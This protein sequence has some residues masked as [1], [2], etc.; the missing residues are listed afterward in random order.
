MV[1]KFP[2]ADLSTMTSAGYQSDKVTKP[3]VLRNFTSRWCFY[4]RRHWGRIKCII[5]FSNDN[6]VA[7]CELCCFRLTRAY[8]RARRLQTVYITGVSVVTVCHDYVTIVLECSGLQVPVA[9]VMRIQALDIAIF[10]VD[11]RSPIEPRGSMNSC[12]G[13]RDIQTHAVRDVDT[14]AVYV[15]RNNGYELC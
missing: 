5:A 6:V 9:V 2:K 3:T 11:L 7:R 4:P 12:D 13:T 8:N 10:G 1:L 14:R 15:L